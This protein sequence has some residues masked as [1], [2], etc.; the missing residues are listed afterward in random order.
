MIPRTP[1]ACDKSGR[2]QCGFCEHDWRRLVHRESPGYYR[3]E[4][5]QTCHLMRVR[6]WRGDWQYRVPM[7]IGIMLGWRPL[8]G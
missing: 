5:C 8:R 6:C 7:P 4:L 1:N 3:A 2:P